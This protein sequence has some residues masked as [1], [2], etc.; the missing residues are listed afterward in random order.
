MPQFAVINGNI[1]LNVIIAE[2]LDDAQELTKMTCV[3][4][5]EENPA[6]VNWHWDGTSF[7]HFNLVDPVE[8]IVDTVE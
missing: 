4:V 8:E 2:S 6:G 3:E 5:T 1:V 7:T